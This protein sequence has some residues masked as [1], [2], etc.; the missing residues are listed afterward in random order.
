MSA[1]AKWTWLVYM[2]G[3][4]NLEGAGRA[5]LDEMRRVGSTDEVKV[6]VQFDTE[7]NRCTRYLVGRNRLNAVQ[8]MPG[9]DCGDPGVLADFIRW[10]MR[11]YPAERWLLDIWNH[12]GGW[13]NL[14]PGHDYDAIRA[15]K[16]FRSAKALRLRRSIFRTTAARIAGMPVEARTIAIDCGSRDYLDNAELRAAVESALPLG[17]KIDVL[18]CDACLMNMLEIAY[19]MRGAAEILVGSEETEPEQGWPYAAILGALVARPSMSPADLART[20][21][22]EYGNWY[23]DGADSATQS[24]LALGRI[25]PIADATDELAALLVKDIRRTAGAAILARDKAQKFEMPEY[26][27]LGDF[28]RQLERQCDVP[29]V[30]A[31]ARA[32]VAALSSPGGFVMRNVA[33]GGRVKRASGV[34]IYFPRESEY[35]PDYRSLLWSK[36]GGWRR[37][38]EALFAM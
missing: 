9:V 31:A 34:S 36:K 5:D 14:E 33:C 17:G 12:G 4:N 18:G 23:R 21:V 38:L 37:F 8:K 26:I 19:E 22:D 27:D 6:L 1:I 7:E 11:S 16:P 10:G 32:V 25:D 24:A 30:K 35:S 28:A 3:D 15:A 20:I 29:A 2:A 13:E